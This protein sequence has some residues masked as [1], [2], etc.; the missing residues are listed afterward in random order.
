[1]LMLVLSLI[2]MLM[3]DIVVVAVVGGVEFEVNVN[4]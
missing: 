4:V 3:C 1:M 2:V